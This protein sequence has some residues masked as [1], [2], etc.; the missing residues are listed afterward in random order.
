MRSAYGIVT[1]LAVAVYVVKRKDGRRNRCQIQAHLRLPDLPARNP[2][3]AT[4]SP[5][6]PA[7]A[8]ER[9]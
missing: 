4:S 1:G 7:P 2:P 8:R 5:S 6:P 3:S 9:S